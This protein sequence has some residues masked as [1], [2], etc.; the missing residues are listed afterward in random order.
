MATKAKA[1]EKKGFQVL[2]TRKNKEQSYLHVLDGSSKTKFEKPKFPGDMQVN[3]ALFV[4][5]ENGKTKVYVKNAY[6]IGLVEFAGEKNEPYKRK[7][8]DG[9]TTELERK[10]KQYVTKQFCYVQGTDSNLYLLV[11]TGT[12]AKG[13]MSEGWADLSAYIRNLVKPLRVLD[14]TVPQ[15]STFAIEPELSSF[16][17]IQYDNAGFE[18]KSDEAI[19]GYKLTLIGTVGLDEDAITNVPKAQPK[20]ASAETI[21][22][23]DEF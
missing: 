13:T 21:I 6:N 9:T 16:Y 5:E 18:H 4:I 17:P 8:E 19:K 10:V 22:D 14:I 12:K 2:S 15:Q 23:E 11:G 7:N 3:E 20:V 1:T